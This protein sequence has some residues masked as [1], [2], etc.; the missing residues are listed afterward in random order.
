MPGPFAEDPDQEH[1]ARNRGQRRGQADPTAGGGRRGRGLLGV[2][3]VGPAAGRGGA[4]DCCSPGAGAGCVGCASGGAGVRDG[5]AAPLGAL[6]APSEPR[7]ERAQARDDPLR[8]GARQERIE[9][10]RHREHPP[11]HAHAVPARRVVEQ[12]PVGIAGARQPEPHRQD[13]AHDDSREQPE[14]QSP[15][16]GRAAQ[17]QQAEHAQQQD[18]P[19]GEEDV[20][21]LGVDVVARAGGD[22]APH[23]VLESTPTAAPRGPRSSSRLP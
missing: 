22:A 8:P 23:P 6:T 14:A 1:H 12:Q 19:A 4:A 3:A 7:G 21:V 15:R 16:Q 10:R 20:L 5:P 11:R 18:Q 13:R 2:A 9:Q 17:A